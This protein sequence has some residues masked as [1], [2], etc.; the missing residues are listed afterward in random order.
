MFQN[1]PRGTDKP[2]IYEWADH[3]EDDHDEWVLNIDKL[4]FNNPFQIGLIYLG[5]SMEF[6]AQ[7]TL[8]L[9]RSE[10]LGRDVSVAPGGASYSYKLF[11]RWNWVLQWETS[12]V[13]MGGIN[14]AIEWPYLWKGATWI[15]YDPVM[16][17]HFAVRFREPPEIHSDNATE[18]GGKLY[19][20][21][22]QL[23]QVWGV[24]W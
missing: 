1:E 4:G 22:W 17:D 14:S 23:E 21:T 19:Q 8:P 13:N 24:S 18:D 11:D 16:A 7:P 3:A 20:I 2:F 10:Y 12:K 15:M 6:R 5:R 9:S